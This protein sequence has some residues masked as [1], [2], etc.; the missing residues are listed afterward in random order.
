MT[1]TLIE[2]STQISSLSR[3]VFGRAI[4]FVIGWGNL[5][6]KTRELKFLFEKLYVRRLGKVCINSFDRL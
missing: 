4:A 3:F 6:I 2:R 1:M 5:K